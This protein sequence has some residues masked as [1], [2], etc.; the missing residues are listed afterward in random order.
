MEQGTSGNVGRQVIAFRPRASRHVTAGTPAPGDKQHRA[1]PVSDLAKF[2]RTDACDDYRQRMIV[3][4]AALAFTVALAAAG[5]W[6]VESM[7][8]V[9]KNQDC[10]LMGRR[11]CSPVVIPAN[12]LAPERVSDRRR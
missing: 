8:V 9:R 7:A 3:N 4:A 1:S 2:E 10:V 12:N 6:I 11:S 5:V